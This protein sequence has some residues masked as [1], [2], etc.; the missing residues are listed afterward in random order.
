MTYNWE[1][2]IFRNLSGVDW[3]QSVLGIIL[4]KKLGRW[5]TL[6]IRG[7]RLLVFLQQSFLWP[8]LSLSTSLFTP[9]LA[10]ERGKNPGWCCWNMCSWICYFFLSQSGRTRKAFFGNL[11]DNLFVPPFNHG[12]SQIWPRFFLLSIEGFFFFAQCQTASVFSDK[13]AQYL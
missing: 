8:E 7:K 1:A 6:E 5:L 12:L 11:S 3:T 4:E 2:D 10:R 13:D 9:A